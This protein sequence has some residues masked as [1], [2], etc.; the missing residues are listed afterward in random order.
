VT[1]FLSEALRAE[2]PRFRLGLRRLEAAHG[3]PNADIRFSA[4][5]HRAAQEKMRALGLDP[6]DTTPEELYHF[7]Q[8]RMRADDARLTKR[9]RTISAT[10]VSA[11]GD[12]VAGMVYAL[13]RLP[14]S[15]GCFALKNSSLRALFKKSPPKRAMKQLG[16]RSMDSF[17]KHE[18]P[19]SVLAAAW[20]TESITWQHR[21]LE[22]YKHLRPNDFESRDIGIISPGSERWRRLAAGTVAQK[23]HN[24]LSLKEAGTLVILP[25]PADAPDGAV[26]ASLSLALHELN[27]IR[28]AGT[29]LKLCQVRPDFGELVRTV[30]SDEPQLAVRLLDRPVSWQLFQRY[31]ARAAERFREEVFGPH[32]RLEDMAWYPIEDALA[33]IEPAFAFWKDSAHLGVMHGRS[34]VSFNVADVALNYCN[35]LPFEKRVA[36]YFRQSLWHELMLRYMDHDA[37]EQSVLSALQPELAK[38]TV[39]A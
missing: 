22:Q 6:M 32:I 1:R 34:P 20:L 18:A 14:D 12:V 8:E 2:E 31:Y 3:N 28:A 39:T 29:F 23:R 5:V 19:S 21:L 15:R 17:L 27:R 33:S 38:E 13:K 10:H 25:L 4:Q 26:T 24:I 36:H 9:L 16:Y 30:A 7:L 35:G 37:V 11:D